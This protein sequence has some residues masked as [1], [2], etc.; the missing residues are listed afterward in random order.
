MK[1]E[2]CGTDLKAE[3]AISEPGWIIFHECVVKGDTEQEAIDNYKKIIM[4][5]YY[6]DYVG[7]EINSDCFKC[8][9]N[10]ST[11]PLHII[12]DI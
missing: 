5:L 10:T 6:S 7:C 9:R 11:N 12:C 2:I 3:P 4:S 8:H 1:C